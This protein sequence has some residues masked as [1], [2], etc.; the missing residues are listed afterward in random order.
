MASASYLGGI[1]RRTVPARPS[2]LVLLPLA[3]PW[4]TVPEALPR[5]A[6]TAPASIAPTR[7]A[8]EAPVPSGPRRTRARAG[9][10]PAPLGTPAPA[11]PTSIRATPEQGEDLPPLV[12]GPVP[13]TQEQADPPAPISEPVVPLLPAGGASAPRVAGRAA[14]HP[15]ERGRLAADGERRPSPPTWDAASDGDPAPTKPGTSVR[16]GTIEVVV[17]PPTP[18]NPPRE[19]RPVPPPRSSLAR[20]YS[21][22]LGLRQV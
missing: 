19:R 4:D 13:A 7:H 14:P 8:L 5:P 6:L 1:A 3:T 20:G 11:P 18:A 15:H 16:I 9:T 22:L 17:A 10:T 2:P 12:A 21:S